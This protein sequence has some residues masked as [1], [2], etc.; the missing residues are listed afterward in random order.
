LRQQHRQ[1][2][3]QTQLVFLINPRS[4]ELEKQLLRQTLPFY[5]QV[6][7][8]PRYFFYHFLIKES[9]NFSK[10]KLLIQTFSH[11]AELSFFDDERLLRQ[12]TVALPRLLDE[13]ALFLA[14]TS[15]QVDNLATD[16]F[17]LLSNHRRITDAQI[18]QLSKSLKLEAVLVE[19]V[20]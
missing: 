9:R 10:H 1:P 20:C 8:V 12:D 16:C 2:R 14:A 13:A 15:A 5:Q 4:S 3:P 19:E 17:Y 6:S 7:F 18:K 11:C